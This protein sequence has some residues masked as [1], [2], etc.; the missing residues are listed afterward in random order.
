MNK[1]KKQMSLCSAITIARIC[2]S[3]T[4]D[5]NDYERSIKERNE[6]FETLGKLRQLSNPLV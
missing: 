6:A 1:R 4:I 5:G 2:I 3:Q